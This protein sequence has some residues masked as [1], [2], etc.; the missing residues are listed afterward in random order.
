MLV[1]QIVPYT[2][3]GHTSNIALLGLLPTPISDALRHRLQRTPYPGANR[4][5]Y[6]TKR[7]SLSCLRNEEASAAPVTRLWTVEHVLK[8]YD[9]QKSL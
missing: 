3:K 9:D 5:S 7:V 4:I 6:V 2:P 1:S 8:K